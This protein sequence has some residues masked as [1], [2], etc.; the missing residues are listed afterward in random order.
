[1]KKLSLL[2]LLTF[3]L[4]SATASVTDTELALKQAFDA[5]HVAEDDSTVAACNRKICQLVNQAVATDSVFDHAFVTV[6]G[7]GSVYSDDNRLRILSWNY[8]LTDGSYGYEAY[9]L[10]RTK[11]KLLTEHWSSDNAQKPKE[12]GIY[13]AKNWYGCLYYKAF[14]QKDRYILLGYSMYSDITKIKVIEVLD[15]DSNQLKLGAP[16]FQPG[17]KPQHRCVFEYSAKANMNIEY[18][19]EHQ[20]FIF[21]HLSPSEPA[22]EGVY[23]Y[24]GPDFTFDSLALKKKLWTL[25]SDIDIKNKE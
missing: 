4:W 23:A 20:R 18:D 22:F 12:H 1:M 17:K 5:L 21:D 10:L 2:L 8:R 16:V 19:P 9:F 13:N 7:L 6:T 24:Y 3:G 15:T 25:E 11:K 14:A